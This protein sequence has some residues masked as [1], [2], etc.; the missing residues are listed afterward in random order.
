LNNFASMSAFG[1]A[2]Q[3]L[4]IGPW[5]HGNVNRAQGDLDFGFASS[6]ALMDL[7]IDLMSQQLQFFDRWLKDAQNGL[8]MQPAVKYFV[9]GANVW[10]TSDTWPPAGR[11]PQEWYLH[12][13]GRANSAAGD[14]V[15]SRERPSAESADSY[16]Y[17]P[18]HPVPTI[19]GATLLPSILRPGPRDQRS[20][21]QRQD[22]LVYTSA[23]LD[24]PLEVVGP[25]SAT[26]YVASDAPDTDFVA[27]LVDVYPNGSAIT[28][29]DGVMRMSHREGPDATLQ[30]LDSSEV[31]CIEV[32][33]W[34]TG[35]VFLP[36]HRIRLDVTS[37]SFPRWE[38]NLNTGE[39][40]ATSTEMRVARQS[41]IHDAAHP[42]RLV[43][44]V[45]PQ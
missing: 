44:P 31:Y 15:L 32:D 43:L 9:M 40:S 17:D 20:I 37:S 33:L 41:V 23:P 42:S 34:A 5:T 29:T 12:S 14:G 8:D 45:M 16:V 1:G 36:G 22:V 39:N 21:E 4:L 3:Y 2:N 11:E 28:V 35:L 27:R 19:G 10:K 7:R 30:P 26:L 25:V 38:R 18:A 13:Q 6:G 24:Q